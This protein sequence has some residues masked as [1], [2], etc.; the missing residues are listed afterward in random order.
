MVPTA[1]S[2]PSWTPTSIPSPTVGV[3]P[4]PPPPP[5]PE[6][7]RE[8]R[9]PS[10]PPRSPDGGWDFAPPRVWHLPPAEAVF[11]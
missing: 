5:T 11:A 9:Y 1:T 2:W 3:T 4:T 10:Q 7:R 8:P 6:P